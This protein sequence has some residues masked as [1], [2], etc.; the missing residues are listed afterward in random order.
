MSR[1]AA[2]YPATRVAAPTN[3]SRL[4]G[5]WIVPSRGGRSAIRNDAPAKANRGER[6]PR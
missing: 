4:T 1:I 2:A 6:G 5:A 3:G